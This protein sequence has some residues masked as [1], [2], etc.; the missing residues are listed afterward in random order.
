MTT[1]SLSNRQRKELLERGRPLRIAVPAP[2][3]EIQPRKWILRA[4]PEIEAA[5]IVSVDEVTLPVDPYNRSPDCPL[6]A[7][8]GNL[9]HLNAGV[10]RLTILIECVV[11]ELQRGVARQPRGLTAWAAGPIMGSTEPGR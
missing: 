3:E 7:L 9:Q 11:V 8:L 1:F 2:D 6:S 10:S 4:L 5:W